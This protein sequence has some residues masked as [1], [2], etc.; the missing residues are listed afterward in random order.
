MEVIIHKNPSREDVVGYLAK[1]FISLG[2][3]DKTP[4][5]RAV[6]NSGRGCY[7]NASGF[8]ISVQNQWFWV[9]AGHIFE[10]IKTAIDTG[11]KL[12][13]WHL[14]DSDALGARSNMP[15][16]FDFDNA[17]RTYFYDEDSGVD[18]ALIYL[19]PYYRNLLQR[20]NIEPLNEQAWR[21][22]LPEDF[23]FYFL[24]GIPDE[25]VQPQMNAEVIIKG[26]MLIPVQRI[27]DP[28]EEILTD[29]PRLYFKISVI[30]INI[31]GMSGGPI[32][33]FRKNNEGQL[34]YWVIALQS[35]LFKNK[36]II[37]ACPIQNFADW[38]DSV[39]EKI[40]YKK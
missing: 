22:G 8:L 32:F 29:M 7:N 21:V 4:G 34:K 18:Y 28:P 17:F 19:E 31:Q 25:C 24:I 5:A 30:N 23:D 39:L 38:I 15:I 13:E 26:C 33:G 36:R 3:F 37:T 16:P 10:D 1:H 11:Q 40:L 27:D 14:D 2:W 20:N 12:G 6:E 9:T 35:G